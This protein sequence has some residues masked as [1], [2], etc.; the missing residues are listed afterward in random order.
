MK[1]PNFTHLDP[2]DLHT[3]QH[4]TNTYIDIDKRHD[5]I[6]CL[7]YGLIEHNKAIMVNDCEQWGSP[8]VSDYRR[9]T[10]LESQLKNK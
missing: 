4:C 10:D 5:G 1:K 2:E 3:C 6:M 8:Y 7:K 9:R